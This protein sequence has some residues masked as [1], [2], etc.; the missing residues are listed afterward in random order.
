[1]YCNTRYKLFL[2]G[3]YCVSILAC[4]DFDAW[5]ADHIVGLHL[6]GRIFNDKSPNV[7]A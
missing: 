7:I 4:N 5:C 2:P 1:M 3:L 6:E